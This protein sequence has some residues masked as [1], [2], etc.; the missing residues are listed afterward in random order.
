M[1]PSGPVGAR[2]R[3][4]QAVSRASFCGSPEAVAQPAMCA[5]ALLRLRLISPVQVP[6]YVISVGGDVLR[7]RMYNNGDDMAANLW[8]CLRWVQHR[9]P[10][11]TLLSAVLVSTWSC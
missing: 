9:H 6:K 1:Q 7:T 4:L 5:N 11:L 2:S 10:G 8:Y 3:Q